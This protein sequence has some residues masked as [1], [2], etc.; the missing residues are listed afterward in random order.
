MQFF[1]KFGRGMLG[2]PLIAE[3]ISGVNASTYEPTNRSRNRNRFINIRCE[4]TLPSTA[5][6]SPGHP[7]SQH[8]C[9]HSVVVEQGFGGHPLPHG[10]K[11]SQFHAFFC[12]SW[13]TRMLATPPSPRVDEPPMGNPG[14]ASAQYIQF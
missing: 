9:L 1:G 8:I 3:E 7:C 10:S 13:Q 11:C 2:L 6:F 5:S 14:S 4:Y 12:K